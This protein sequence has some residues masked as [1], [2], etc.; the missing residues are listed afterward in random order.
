VKRILSAL[1][2][3]SALVFPFHKGWAQQLYIDCAPL[4]PCA[5]TGP[6]DTHTGDALYTYGYKTNTNFS[7]LFGMFGATGLLIGNG[8]VPNALSALEPS[9][10][11]TWCFNWA[12]INGIPTLVSCPSGGTPSFSVL[13]PGTNTNGAMLV[14]NGASLGPTGSG[15][16]T[17]NQITATSNNTLTTLSALSLPSSQVTG[18]E[19]LA[20]LTPGTGVVSAL[21]NNVGGAGAFVV[22]GGDLGTPSSGIATN[23]TGTASG[24]NIGGNAATASA[25]NTTGSNGTFWGVS[26]GVQGWYTPS[27]GGGGV[28]SFSGD[29]SLLNNVTSTGAV[30]ATLANAGGY[31]IWGNTGSSSGAPGYHAL[32]S[33]SLAAFPSGLAQL[34]AAQVW[35][36]TQ[37]F[38]S[39]DILIQ[40]SSTGT[41]ALA[42]A[43]AGA[44]NYIATFPAATDTVVEL[45]AT[46]TLTN[47]SISGSEITSAVATATN[48]SSYPALCTGGQFSEGL[49]S[50]SNNCGT[51]AGGGNMSNSGSPTQ[52][53]TAAF[54]NV[55]AIEG[56][57][58]GTAGQ[59]YVSGGASAYPSFSSTLSDVTSVNGTTIPASQTLLYSGGALGTPSSGIATNLTGTAS[60]LNIGG[61]AANLSGTP[62]LPN[63]TTATT[64]TTGDNTTKLAT[65]AFVLANAGGTVTDGSGTSTANEVAVSTSETHQITYVTVS[66]CLQVSGGVLSAPSNINAQTGTS[67]TIASTDACKLVTFSNTSAIAV[68]L[69]Q[70]TGSFSNGFQFDVA[71]YNT[72]LVTITPTTSTINGASSLA[73]PQNRSCEI[74]SDGT[75]WQVSLCTAVTPATNLAAS[76]VGGVTGNLP[77]TNLNGGT[78]ASSSTFWRGDG[79]WAAPTA[80]ASSVTPGT[81]TVVGATA[82]CMLDNSTGTTMACPGTLLTALVPAFTGDVTNTAGSL[83]TTVNAI[84]GIAV[85]VATA[86]SST[87]VTP[88]CTNAFTKVTA[89]ATGTFTIN[90]PG[91]CTPFDGQKLELKIIS[92]SGGTITYSWNSA[93]LA[94]A[95]LALPTTSNAASK[96]DYFEF[97]YDADKSGWVFL[98]DNQGF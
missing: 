15:T 60:G 43:N 83:A 84:K 67:Y 42:S 39:S 17:A 9:S 96:E 88:N 46:Q 11:G 81:T 25:F 94:S 18:L 90:A 23:L 97:Q 29:G 14:G 72:G 8:A 89:S 86:S 38:P 71:N 45:A 91:T 59:A 26:G 44:S 87:S 16:V 76:G 51:P 4:T 52:Y 5:A 27:G 41:T 31:N 69:P 7:Q 78:A 50:G 61:T 2:L 35:S 80:A 63:G 37:T 53:Q 68:T 75:N 95:T 36:A 19:A 47:K 40:G 92:P 6:Y 1:L 98:A 55:T 30:T 22:Y 56:I 49:S 28:S 85:A 48:L 32:S 20:T 13:T 34:A 21:E 73:I 79:T 64:Q 3:L 70:A 74:T 66:G 65:D 54:V 58:P 33:F 24:L 12:T 57:G 82:P 77:V 93:Y 62:A 10:A